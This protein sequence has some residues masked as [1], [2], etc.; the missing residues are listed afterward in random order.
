M[1]RDLWGSI[2]EWLHTTPINHAGI[3]AAVLAGAVSWAA[4]VVLAR[5]RRKR[6]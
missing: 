2:W 5:D 6:P 4:F 1:M 3:A